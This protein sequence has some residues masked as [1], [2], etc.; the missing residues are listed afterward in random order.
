MACAVL[1]RQSRISRRC[2]LLRTRSSG[3]FNQVETRV[4]RSALR[5]LSQLRTRAEVYRQAIEQCER[6]K[7]R[8]MGFQ[9]DD[10]IDHQY[11]V[12]LMPCGGAV[13]I[14]AIDLS[15]APFRQT[16]GYLRARAYGSPYGC[17]GLYYGA[18][19]TS[20]SATGRTR[21]SPFNRGPL[22]ISIRHSMGIKING[23]LTSRNESFE[24]L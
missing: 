9:P 12:C 24:P 1:S 11:E 17:R 13:L 5:I 16:L 20:R 21:Q 2:T 14:D 3:A 15:D 7:S 10:R 6:N 22:V 18:T 4:R 23:L 8:F 19:P